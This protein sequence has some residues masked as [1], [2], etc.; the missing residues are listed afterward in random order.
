[1]PIC[2]SMIGTASGTNY[3]QP[4]P[5]RAPL[6]KLSC[7]VTHKKLLS[8]VACPLAAARLQ[9]GYIYHVGERLL[10]DCLN[11]YLHKRVYPFT[12]TY[13]RGHHTSFLFPTSSLPLSWQVIVYP[14]IGHLQKGIEGI[15]PR[16]EKQGMSSRKNLHPT[17]WGASRRHFVGVVFSLLQRLSF[18]LRGQWCSCPKRKNAAT[19]A[20]Y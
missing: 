9:F 20:H 11:R 2:L 17:K 5:I 16:Q 7:W 12:S 19:A 18:P 3:F 1:M 8:I 10:Q 13:T 15:V 14:A 6:P 4:D